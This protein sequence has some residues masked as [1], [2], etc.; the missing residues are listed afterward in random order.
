MLRL[1]A[2]ALSLART[3]P[4]APADSV[5]RA[6][7]VLGDSFAQYRTTADLRANFGPGRLYTVVVRP[8]LATLDTAVRFAGHPTMRIS[9]P[10]GTD[11]TTKLEVYLP[12]DEQLARLWL[13]MTVRFSPGWTTEGAA[14]GASANS[15]K[16][17]GWGWG[18]GV[19]GRGTVEI[20]NTRQYQLNT[21]AVGR[22]V[23]PFAWAR[24]GVAGPEWTDGAWYDYVVS[25]EVLSPTTS[26]TR[27]W[28][29]RAGETP[30]LAA[31]VMGT[32]TRG[33]MPA[34]RFLLLGMNFNQVRRDT[35]HQAVWI[36]RWEAV[37]GAR[38][39]NPFGVPG[40][41]IAPAP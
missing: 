39:A 33:Q 3:D 16:L 20:T 37:D 35:Q 24:A 21:G 2:F 7:P 32:A 6:V 14:T 26:R 36:G 23:V 22:A 15:Y 40:A 11:A 38:H 28:R 10:G 41:G 30:R 19:D 9:Q 5:R 34:V 13:R 27:L 25:Y 4:A 12:R 31:T 17:L 29:A 1:L 8:E 18:G